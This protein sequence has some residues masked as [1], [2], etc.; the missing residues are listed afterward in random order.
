MTRLVLIRHGKTAWNKSGKYQGQSDVALSEEG[1]EQARCLAEHFPVEKL[2]AVYASDLSRAM[3]TAE[4]VAQ[5]FGLEVRPEPA[6]RELS[7]GK[8]EGLTYAEIVAGWPEAMANFL[9]HPDI[10][11]IPQG[12]SFPQVQQRAMTRLREI[13]AEHEPHDHTVGIFAHGAVLRTILTGIMQMPLSQ[14][15]TLSQY[16]T[17]VNIVRFDEGRPTVELLNSTAHLAM[18]GLSGKGKI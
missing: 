17:A 12:E 3:V 7:F 8:W 5:K 14:V 4:T 1:L 13:V 15:W 9:T 18:E 16:N 10:M 2:D 6:F 11:E